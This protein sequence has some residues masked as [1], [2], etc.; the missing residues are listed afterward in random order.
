MN[1][2]RLIGMYLLSMLCYGSGE[3]VSKKYSLAPSMMLYAAA[4]ILYGLTGAA[5]LPVIKE[6]KSLSILGTVWNVS[7]FVITLFLGL[8][9]FKE[10]LNMVQVV[11]V[12]FGCISI[13]IL[14]MS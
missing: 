7:Y 1:Y 2:Y 10:Q 6:V 12:I 11:G 4:V 8:V 3:Y 5:W 13:F 14:A 9:I